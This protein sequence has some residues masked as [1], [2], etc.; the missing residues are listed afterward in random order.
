V[1]FDD[2]AKL[3]QLEGIVHPAVRVEMR[4]QLD[5]LPSNAVAVIEVIK[6][7]ESGWADKCDQVWV[8]HCPPEQQVE[9]L[10]RSRGMSEAEARRRVAAQNPQSEKLAR[11][12]VVIDT[13]GTLEQTREQ[14]L[15]AWQ[16]LNVQR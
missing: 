7:F 13:S 8:T 2:A 14:V 11:A 3:R 12:D 6:L 10:M 9:R 15:R 1:V 5:A 4:R 16:S